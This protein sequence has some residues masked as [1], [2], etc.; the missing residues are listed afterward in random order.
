MDSEGWLTE[1]MDGAESD[2]TQGA[3]VH[4]TVSSSSPFSGQFCAS[5][6]TTDDQKSQQ[7]KTE[8]A[9]NNGHY[10]ALW[11]NCGTRKHCVRS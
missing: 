4:V 6:E 8:Y 1:S 2:K 9:G 5:S 11:R 3:V 10:D 7:R